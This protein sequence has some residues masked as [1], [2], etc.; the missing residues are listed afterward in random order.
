MTKHSQDLIVWS[1]DGNRLRLSARCGE[2]SGMGRVL[3][4]NVAYDD[5]DA[6]DG[7]GWFG[8]DPEKPV[9]AHAGS[10]AKVAMLSARYARGVPLWHA[11]DGCG[12]DLQP[13]NLPDSHLAT[14]PVTSAETVARR[15]GNNTNQHVARLAP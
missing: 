9:M 5:C 10:T 2:C 4:S 15:D 3:A 7:L 14:R 13:Q 11:G 1:Q 12:L 6:C 8:I